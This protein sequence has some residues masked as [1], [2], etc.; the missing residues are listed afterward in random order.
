MKIRKGDTVKI[1]YGKDSGRTGKVVRVFRKDM[2]V[3]VEG[4]NEFKKSV[5]GDGRGRV[6]E[7]A[8]I[9]KPLP[10]SKVMLV[11]PESGKSTRIKMSKSGKGKERIAV[12]TGKSIETKPTKENPKKGVETKPV[13]KKKKEEVKKVVKSATEGGDKESI[14]KKSSK[15]S[16]DKK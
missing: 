11:D 16:K 8:T 6:A 13:S 15:E 3:V 14:D 2:K 1:L 7:I 4:V 9:L 5:K 12:R 10:V